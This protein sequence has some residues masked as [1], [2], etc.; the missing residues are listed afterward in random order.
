MEIFVSE[1]NMSERLGGVVLAHDAAEKIPNLELIWVDSG[2]SGPRFSKSI[3]QLLNAKVEVIKRN[4]KEFEFL[5]RRWVVERTF[6]WL[7]K[8]R[9]LV[10]DL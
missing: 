10:E 2:Y 3:E 4:K 7:V 8:N 1:A 6:A 9:R 5:P